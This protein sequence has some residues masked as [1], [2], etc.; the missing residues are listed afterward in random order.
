VQVLSRGKRAG[1]AQGVGGSHARQAL[2]NG[3]AD[4]RRQLAEA[5]E[6]R[7]TLLGVQRQSAADLA[8]ATADAEAARREA[9]AAGRA[10]VQATTQLKVA[11]C[12]ACARPA[13][14]CSCA[15][16]LPRD[17]AGKRAAQA[18][19]RSGCAAHTTMVYALV[20]KAHS[21]APCRPTPPC[22]PGHGLSQ[23]RGRRGTLGCRRAQAAEERGASLAAEAAVLG[24]ELTRV[25]TVAARA[26]TREMA[27]GCKDEGVVPV[28]MHMEE[29]RAAPRATSPSNLLS[30]PSRFVTHEL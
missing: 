23:N 1:P 12:P 28:A 9:A 16:W 21:A 26:T 3:L 18:G 27:G 5:G 4:L 13:P 6:E 10:L 25:G 11:G 24:D 30:S 14:A 20:E 17:Q 19:P 2:Q 8:R 7:G 22:T 29:A 15:R